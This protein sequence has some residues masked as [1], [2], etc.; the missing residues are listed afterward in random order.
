MEELKSATGFV[1]GYLAYEQ[2]PFSRMTLT[3]KSQLAPETL[4][5]T[6]RGQVL[7]LD[8]NQPIYNI[9]T[10]EQ[11][12]DES[13]ATEKLNLTLWSIFAAIALTLALVGVYGVMSYA[14]TQRTHEIGIRVALGARSRDVLGLVIG[15][16]MKLALAGVAGGL[17]GAWLL[18]RLMAA[19]LFGVS[20][21]DPWTFAAVALVL[22]L[23]A[24]AACWIPARRATKVDPMV[25]LRCE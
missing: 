5:P 1:Q 15:Q 7:A 12:R 2:M 23:V 18:S 16:G 19:W 8:P 4:I 3:V 17:L 13:I 22:A 25:A 9:R 24:L 20:A 11:I 10:M 6:V 21:T 14:V